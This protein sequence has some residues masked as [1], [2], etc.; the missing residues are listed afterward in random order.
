MPAERVLD[1][2]LVTYID[3]QS[4]AAESF[5]VLRTNIQFLGLD[6]PVRSILVTST[7]AGEGKSFTAANL[8]I[9]MA[10]AG[11]RVILI[12]ADLRRPNLH[13]LF[14]LGNHQAGLTL[15]VASSPDRE[16]LIHQTGVK[17]LHVLTSGPLPPNPA[18][19]LG[20]A[21]M[22]SL[23]G[24]LKQEYDVVI[25][26]S[27]PVLAV[28]DAAILSAYVDGLLLVVCPGDTRYQLVQKA[29]QA[30]DRV[31]AR[32]LGV[33]LDGVKINGSDSYYYHYRGSR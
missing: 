7:A 17:D 10:Q 27:P 3:P 12:D 24:R 6:K 4:P 28:A 33:V 5:R 15:A 22:A 14:G 18:E 2:S 26:D 21:R 1:G 29:R 31:K 19:L 25:I 8:A 16:G 30:L 11:H 23:V 9:A 20:S 13:R 32:I